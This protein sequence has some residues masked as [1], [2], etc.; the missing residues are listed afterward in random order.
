MSRLLVVST[1]KGIYLFYL[2]VVG[3]LVKL[4]KKILFLQVGLVLIVKLP[5]LISPLLSFLNFSMLYVESRLADIL[6]LNDY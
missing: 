5:L 4:N 1:K 2:S 6:E 3:C